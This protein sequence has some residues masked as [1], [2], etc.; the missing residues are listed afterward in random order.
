MFI[1]ALPEHESHL[2]SAD[3]RRSASSPLANFLRNAVPGQGLCSRRIVGFRHSP[4]ML[5]L[6]K[7]FAE[8]PRFDV[9]SYEDLCGLTNRTE[10]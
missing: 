5:T 2:F 4:W 1:L 10:I 3:R 8:I 6:Q 7:L 9:C